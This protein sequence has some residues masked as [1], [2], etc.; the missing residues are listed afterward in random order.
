MEEYR[1]PY[2]EFAAEINNLFK[3]G[4]D[5]DA[6]MMLR[7]YGKI[8]LFFF[9]YF[10]LGYK[11][12]HPFL[13]Q[14]VYDCQDNANNFM[15]LWARE[16]LKSTIRSCIQPIH[17]VVNNPNHRIAIFSF[18]RAMGRQHLRKIKEILEGNKLIKM[19]FPEIFYEKPS[20]QS[21]KWSELD[22]LY[23]KRNIN[24]SEATFS[25]YGLIETLPTGSHFTH[26]VYD[27][28]VNE[29]TIRN[30]D[31][32]AKA[33]DAYDKSLY[34]KQ[35]GG[36]MGIVGTHYG[37]NDPYYQILEKKYSKIVV[38][39]IPAEVDENGE[40]KIGGKPVFMSREELDDRVYG[41]NEEDYSAQMLLKPH[42]RSK[43]NLK[44][45]DLQFY[46][47][48]EH[49]KGMIY[50][51]IVDPATKKK[52]KSDY[53][54]M[55]VIGTTEQRHFYVVDLIRDK[56]SLTER[57]TALK[58]LHMKW[59]PRA[60]G[61]ESYGI[62][63]DLE[64]FEERRRY[65]RYYFEI[66]PLG[67]M[68]S[69]VDRIERLASYFKNKRIYLPKMLMYVNSEGQQLDMVDVFINEEYIYFPKPK[70]DDMLDSLARIQ[71]GKMEIQFPA[72]TTK[73][74]GITDFNHNGLDPYN[75]KKE[76][77]NIMG[78]WF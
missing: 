17:M 9:A 10:I 22:G 21:F 58:D 72:E 36:T 70:H 15:D 42:F 47:V 6:L 39:E 16:H 20:T 75:I 64:Y 35:Q 45:E 43:T 4:R 31:A 18:S 67:G 37:M 73:P 3:I 56:L 34:L 25:A 65:E 29:L 28:I 44:L 19:V 77:T 5:E 7:T 46:N 51:I 63:A 53:T 24:A 78:A 48:G 38:N 62:Q 33:M 11:F 74:S 55:W 27:D 8:D 1:A 69:K 41:S 23:V 61:Y 26:R 52:K 13:V 30:P 32:V 50:Y 14:R 57:W 60:V 40:G 12:D 68:I 49:P 66:I 76:Q 71:D 54:V 2:W 59:K